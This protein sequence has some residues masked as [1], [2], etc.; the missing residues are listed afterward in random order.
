MIRDKLAKDRTELANERTFLSFIR[1]AIMIF[2]S[3]ITFI[4]VFFEDKILVVLG[5][6]LIPVSFIFFIIGLFVFKKTRKKINE[7]YRNYE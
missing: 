1:T 4:K 6:F 2:A 5:W 7:T 3:G